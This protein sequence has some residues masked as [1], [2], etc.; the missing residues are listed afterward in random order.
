MR[1]QEPTETR[2]NSPSHVLHLRL[3]RNGDIA[4]DRR[5]TFPRA[6][7]ARLLAVAPMLPRPRSTLLTLWPNR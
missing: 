3:W 2:D 1:S 4:V 5:A 6:E 7:D